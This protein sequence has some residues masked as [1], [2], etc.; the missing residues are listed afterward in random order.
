[1]N[2]T[3]STVAGNGTLGYS[4]DGGPATSAQ[5]AYPCGVALDQSGD[6][7][8]ADSGNNVIREVTTNGNIMTIAGNNTRGFSGNEGLAIAAQLYEPLGLAFDASG[9]LYV[10]DSGNQLIRVIDTN[11]NINAFAGILEAGYSGDGGLATAAQFYYPKGLAMDNAGNLYIADMGNS[12]IRMISTKGIVTTVAGNGTAGSFGDGGAATLAQLSF[13]DSVAVD[14]SGNLYIADI[15]NQRIREVVANGTIT[16]IAGNGT[17]GYSGDG[18]P[19]IQAE[20]YDPASVAVVFCSKTLCNGVADGTVYVADEDNNV[21]RMLTPK[22]P[23]ADQSIRDT[24][25]N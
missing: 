3:I 16:T 5:L 19:A 18:G 4:G 7:Y 10:S 14:S 9:N 1:V 11:G 21:I 23:L 24:R 8:I 6:I 20:F 22:A 13:P 17:R 2:G 25:R 15:G 12:V